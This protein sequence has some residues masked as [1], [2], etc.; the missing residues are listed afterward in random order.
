MT[1]FRQAFENLPIS[2]VDQH[3]FVDWDG[4]DDLDV[5]KVDLKGRTCGKTIRKACENGGF[6]SG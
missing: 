5:I 6:S 1:L 3:V 4:D 2:F